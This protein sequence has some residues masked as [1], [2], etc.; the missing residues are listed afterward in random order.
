MT[1]PACTGEESH[2]QTDVSRSIPDAAGLMAQLRLAHHHMDQ[3]AFGQAKELLL[4]VL[5]KWNNYPQAQLALMQVYREQ[6]SLEDVRDFFSQNTE[7]DTLYRDLLLV[8]LVRTL[9]RRQDA[10]TVKVSKAI[11][12]PDL[13][14]QLAAELF[15]DRDAKHA[16]LVQQPFH[17]ELLRELSE[18]GEARFSPLA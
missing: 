3:Q 13:Q 15:E 5:A 14:L 8:E 12:S 2:E 6:G 4:D 1:M 11:T 9:A 10:K 18:R 17:A 16:L 7:L